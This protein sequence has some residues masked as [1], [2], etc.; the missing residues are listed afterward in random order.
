MSQIDV[1]SL[2]E[3]ARAA[4]QDGPAWIRE[5]DD[6]NVNLVVL[7]AGHSI[8][9]H[10]NNEVDVV[11]IGVDGTGRVTIGGE[12]VELTANQLLIVP[13]GAARSIV[14][15]GARFAYVTCHKRR[16]GLWPSVAE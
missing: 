7:R 4:Q 3:T 10:V 15:H 2:L 12:A 8:A 6:L 16:T 9:E 14:P 11:L 1:V 5:T 13:K